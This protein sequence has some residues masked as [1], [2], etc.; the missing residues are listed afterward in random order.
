MT[1]LRVSFYFL[2]VLNIACLAVAAMPWLGFE[3]LFMGTSEPERMRNQLFPEKLRVLAST[4]TDAASAPAA[5]ASVAAAEAPASAPQAAASEVPAAASA[6]SASGTPALSS[7]ALACVAISNLSADQAQSLTQ[8]ARAADKSIVVR[9]GEAAPSAYWVNIPPQGGKA[10]AD[11]RAAELHK[12]GLEDFFI[13]QEAGPNRYAISLGLFR[14]DTLAR[15]HLETLQKRGVKGAT[16]STRYNAN[17]A[18]V[19]IQGPG[20]VLERLL[21]AAQDSIKGSEQQSCKAAG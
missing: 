13:V 19:E 10:G 11:R 5:A 21:Q 3:P 12:L 7:T 1:G 14:G 2:L 4:S 6:V 9:E 20:G 16:V 18:R 17:S 15:R 8:Q